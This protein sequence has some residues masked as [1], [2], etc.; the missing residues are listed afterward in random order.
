M[1]YRVRGLIVTHLRQIDPSAASSIGPVRVLRKKA[2]IALWSRT[3][4]C[5]PAWARP[6]TPACASSR[7]NGTDEGS[8]RPSTSR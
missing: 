7:R 5:W 1:G 8:S 4:S 3:K 6:G 2:V